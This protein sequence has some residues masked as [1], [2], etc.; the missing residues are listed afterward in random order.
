VQVSFF[1]DPEGRDAETLLDAWH[2]LPGVAGGVARAGVEVTIVQ[3]ATRR[4]TVERQ[5]VTF[6]FVED[7]RR[8]PPR[9][10]GGVAIGRP[11]LNQVLSL[12]PDVVH[13]HGIQYLGAVWQLA[14]ALPGVPVLVQDHGVQLPGGW[15]RLAWR[16]ACRR[17]SGAIFASRPQAARFF[18]ARV[19][20]PDLP[21]F[22]VIEGSSPFTPGDREAAR[23][24]TGLSGDPCF[25][26]TGTL[27][28]NKDPLAALEAFRLACPR[29]PDARLWC[30]YSEAPL[31]EPVRRRIA[32]DE[33]LRRRVTLLGRRPHHE[34]EQLYRAADF[35]L[36]MSHREA[37]GFSP[38]EAMSCGTTPLLTDIPSFRRI[39][40][41]GRAGSLTPV[42]DAA[43]MAEAMVAWAGRDRATL[44]STARAHFERLLS[45]DAIGR[46]L[47]DVYQSVARP[48]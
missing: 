22:E 15:R 5:G 8:I 31:L 29:L 35:F 16:V 6:H 14:G 11:I 46:Q 32:G 37:C 23:R 10:P 44:R 28:H 21:V 34:M 12:A 4:Q 47:R 33:A 19:F 45:Y 38:I 36:Q 1:V 40:D 9:L 24:A 3:A 25:L 27:N 43:A 17:L 41:E 48:T 7:G 2:T 42:G 30:C 18:E 39:S 20:R 13:V 26:W